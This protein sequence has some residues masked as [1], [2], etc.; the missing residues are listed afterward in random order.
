MDLLVIA[1]I[2]GLVEG[3]T[4]FLPISSTGHLI[5]VGDALNFL[6]DKAG[7]FE[8]V[9]QSGAI[10]AV[11]VLYKERFLGLLKPAELGDSFRGISGIS[12]LACACAPAMFLGFILHKSI[13]FYL[14]NPASVATALI[15]GG[16]VMLWLEHRRPAASI[17]SLE[18]ITHRTA[19]LIG[20]FQCFALWPG[21]SRSGATIVGAMLLGAKRAVA[22][23]FS[24]LIATPILLAATAYELY[25]SFHLLSASDL[26][27]FL[28][29]FFVSFISALLAVKAFVRILSHWN[30]VPFAIYRIALGAVVLLMVWR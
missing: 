21:I 3:I 25:K 18:T 13:K 26:P 17:N 22:A 29:G 30:L 7:T 24:F 19:F 1:V 4:E 12:K 2:L 16:L 5:L 14:F 23:E 6:G 11:L 10:L 20:C 8:I 15:V 28:M 27:V 9:I